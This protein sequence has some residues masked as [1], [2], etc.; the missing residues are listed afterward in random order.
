MTLRGIVG[1]QKGD[2]ETADVLWQVICSLNDA[3]NTLTRNGAE[4]PDGVKPAADLSDLARLDTP[5]S[6][7]LLSQLRAALMTAEAVDAQRGNV[8]AGYV[9]GPDGSRGTDYA[10]SVSHLAL[11]LAGEIEPP[12]GRD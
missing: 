10:E 2:L 6:R 4:N 1:R 12:R 9:P 7:Q 11:R 5:A 3:V 8:M